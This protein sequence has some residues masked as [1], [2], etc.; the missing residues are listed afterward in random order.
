MPKN[1]GKRRKNWRKKRAS[2]MTINPQE[3]LLWAI[4]GAKVGDDVKP[5]T[6]KDNHED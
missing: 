2:L 4:F 3:R 5:D 1:N 6:D